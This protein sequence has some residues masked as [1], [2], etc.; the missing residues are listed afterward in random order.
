M[1]TVGMIR[2]IFFVCLVYNCNANRVS[3]FYTAPVIAPSSCVGCI[4]RRQRSNEVFCNASCVLRPPPTVRELGNPDCQEPWSCG[5]CHERHESSFGDA[6]QNSDGYP[7]N[8]GRRSM[9]KEK[10]M[11]VVVDNARKKKIIIIPLSRRGENPIL[12][13]CCQWK[14]FEEVPL[15]PRWLSSCGFEKE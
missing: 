2:H 1:V 5:Q 7:P 9:K 8:R 13:Q 6:R 11:Q 3:V 15:C 12:T 4:L 14:V 10:K